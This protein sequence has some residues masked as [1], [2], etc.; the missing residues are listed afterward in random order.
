MEELCAKCEEYV[1]VLQ[2][3]TEASTGVGTAFMHTSLSDTDVRPDRSGFVKAMMNVDRSLL[4]QV[5]KPLMNKV[6]APVRQK[7]A[8]MKNL[9]GTIDDRMF[10]KK[11]YD[12]YLHKVANLKA[13]LKKAEKEEAIAKLTDQVDRNEIKLEDWKKKLNESTKMLR[14]IFLNYKRSEGVLV[15]GEFKILRFAHARFFLSCTKFM[16]EIGVD[17]KEEAPP[18]AKSLM[19]VRGVR[20]RST[21]ISINSVFHV[22]IT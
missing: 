21:R 8:E 3:F 6:L 7:I 19:N 5:R 9:Q 2:A 14:K 10:Q 13:K 18:D 17:G 1:E 4:D 22:S 16:R 15:D 20:A 11:E 12:H